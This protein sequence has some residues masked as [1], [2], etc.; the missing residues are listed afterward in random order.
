MQFISTRFRAYWLGWGVVLALIPAVLVQ[1]QRGQA[2]LTSAL[3][4]QTTGCEEESFYS[5]W[6]VN[7]GQGVYVDSSL[8]PYSSAYFNWLFYRAYGA[9]T[10]RH[11][12]NQIPYWGRICTLAGAITAFLLCG[13]TLALAPSRLAWSTLA[14][15]AFLSSGLF[16]WWL[17]T[18]RPDVWAMTFEIASAAWFLTFHAR[19][20]WLAILG[21]VVLAYLAWSFKQA[22]L[23]AIVT[24]VLFLVWQRQKSAMI[25]AGIFGAMVATTLLLGGALYRSSLASAATGFDDQLGWMNLLSA[26]IHALP[27]T[28]LPVYALALWLG[29]GRKPW[30]AD[31]PSKVQFATIGLLVSGTL[32]FG[33]GFKIGASYNY[34]FPAVFFAA[35]LGVQSRFTLQHS[36]ALR[37]SDTVVA[38][39]LCASCILACLNLGGRLGTHSL[40]AA[41]TELE[42]RLKVWSALPIPR[43]SFD[44]RLALPW[45]NPDGP[46]FLPAYNYPVDRSR[47]RFFQHDGV[48][49]LILEGYFAALVLPVD[50]QN[51]YDQGRLSD[52]YARAFS[53]AGLTVYQ[54]KAPAPK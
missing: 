1:V 7:H 33:A 17:F 51:D 45:L 10:A 38:I 41:N 16:G 8:Q 12:D 4:T 27:V 28:V 52:H 48:G 25:A 47:H 3:P 13:W 9:V 43:F 50:T 20:P 40:A 18:V 11:P 36:P 5:L 46:V 2:A 37:I 22:N 19:R 29:D 30:T 53:V 26:A 34:Y 23:S 24:V 15:I 44:R 14:G 49:G 32:A 39:A 54:R 21:S 31:V 6:R 42:Q 35:L